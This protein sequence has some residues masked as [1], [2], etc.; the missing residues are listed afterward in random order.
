MFITI[1]YDY[2]YGLY[3]Y[4]YG[5]PLVLGKVLGKVLGNVVIYYW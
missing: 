2:Y 1:H 3:D 5:L 4:Y